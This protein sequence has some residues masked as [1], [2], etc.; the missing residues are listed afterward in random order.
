[1]FVVHLITITA[2]R[3][4]ISLLLPPVPCH[5]PGVGYPSSRTG[6]GTPIW[7]WLGYPQYWSGLWG[8]PIQDKIGY[9]TPRTGYAPSP[10]HNTFPMSPPQRVPHLHPTVVSGP[11]TRYPHPGLNWVPRT[12]PS[13]LISLSYHCSISMGMCEI[14]HPFIF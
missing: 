13:H 12:L 5:F 3:I 11:R 14:L 7:D 1:M 6:W 8:T 4:S 9:P 10:S 2:I